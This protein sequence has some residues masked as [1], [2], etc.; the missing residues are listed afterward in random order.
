MHP[1][2]QHV[3]WSSAGDEAVQTLCRLLRIDTSNPPGDTRA[4][5]ALCADALDR[6]GAD[7][8]VVEAAPGHVNVVGR[9]RARGADPPLL[10][11]AH[12]DVVP[13]EPH[14]W[15]HPPFGGEEADGYLWGRGAVDM[16]NMAAMSLAVVRLLAEA[17]GPRRRDVIFAGVADEEA[18]CDH[19]SAFL[20]A[21]HP[22]LVRAGF[23][24]GEVGGF[25][26]DV[27]GRAIYPIQV[28]EKGTCWIRARAHGTAGHGSIP[29]DDNA[30]VAMS[31]FLA[32]VGARKLKVR[33]SPPVERFLADL[34]RTQAQPARA[35]LPKLCTP[36]CRRWWVAPSQ[37]ALPHARSR[38]WSATR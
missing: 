14:G 3:D 31:R 2:L 37:I 34:A 10:L 7:R 11:N 15:T 5:A 25:T 23:A 36:R 27:G 38:R 35:L 16:K 33:P 13:A 29:R 30:V 18:G 6:A 1:A 24:L 20:V 12:L 19:G 28:A 22:D 26:M 21:Q 17:G 4:A 8:Q 9:M 32:K